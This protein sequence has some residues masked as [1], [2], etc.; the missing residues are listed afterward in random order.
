MNIVDNIN[1]LI[2]EKNLTKKEFAH[3][4]MKLE[5]KCSRVGETPSLKTIYAYL[6]GSISIKAELI[7]YIAEVLGVNEQDIF[8]IDKKIADKISK[9]FN[10]DN[11][12]ELKMEVVSLLENIPQK[13]LLNIRDKLWEYH[14]LTNNLFI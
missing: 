3:R 5:P 6:N 2:K 8:G 14:S 9:R 1:I 4:L 12:S 10:K 11:S 13:L 7:P